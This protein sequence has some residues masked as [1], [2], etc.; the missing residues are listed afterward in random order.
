MSG[1]SVVIPTYNR[2]GLIGETLAAVFAQSLPPDEIIVVDD[3]SQDETRAVLAGYG[4]RIRAIHATNQG[5]LV[6]RNAGLRAADGPLVAFCDSDDLWAPDFLEA[7]RMQWRHEPR[8][9]AC[10]ADFHILQAGALSGRSKFEDAPAGYWTG[11][12]MVSADSMVFDTPMVARLLAFQPFF[13]S[14]MMVSRAAFLALG[15][16]DEG[17]SRILGCDMA[18]A[19]RV[20]ARP[21]LGVL[22]R[23][24]VAIR[25]H[26]GNISADTEKMNLGDARVLE[27]VVRTRP[28]LAPLR[29][30]I[31]RSVA[32]RRCAALDSAFARRDFAAVREISRLLASGSVPPR[33]RAKSLIA[34]LPMPVSRLAASLLSR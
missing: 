26:G 16:W 12:R 17:V 20:A 9:T 33:Q 24:L 23:P 11:A 29:G 7:M 10:Y 5:D 21:P 28:E 30:D 31:L 27:H 18:T 25:K 2:A 3:G 13:P 22:R 6:A 19:L 32:E 4:G 1:I 14:C 15:G 8:L 34:A